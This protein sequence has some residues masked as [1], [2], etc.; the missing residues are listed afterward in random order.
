MVMAMRAVRAIL[1]IYFPLSCVFSV[2]LADAMSVRKTG[3]D[4]KRTRLTDL[5]RGAYASHS[6]IE[7]LL[8]DA[9]KTGSPMPSVRPRS[10]GRARVLRE[11]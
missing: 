5:S 6:A 3:G 8:N 9:K 2:G 11:S 4:A 1:S 10:T 7:D